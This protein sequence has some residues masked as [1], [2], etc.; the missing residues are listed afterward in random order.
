MRAKNIIKPIRCVQTF[1]HSVHKQK[2]KIIFS[3]WNSLT[4]AHKFVEETRIT[5]APC[6]M[7]CRRRITIVHEEE[8]A[9]GKSKVIIN[10]VSTQDVLI[11][12]IV[13][14]C[15]LQAHQSGLW[16]PLKATAK[17]HL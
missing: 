17:A 5:S 7:S 3:V 13:G 10:S 14:L 4:Y 1:A 2:S 6:G 16:R 8:A 12:L 9:K 11:A 15:L